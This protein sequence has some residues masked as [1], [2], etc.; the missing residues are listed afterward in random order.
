MK[1][2]MKAPFSEWKKKL[3]RI[4]TRHAYVKRDRELERQKFVFI[5]LNLKNMDNLCKNYL[6][7]VIICIIYRKR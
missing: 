5:M 6:M 7:P 2:S 1:F 4:I 3:A